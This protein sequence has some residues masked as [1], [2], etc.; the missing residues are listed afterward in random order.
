MVDPA[1]QDV[2]QAWDAVD[3][4]ADAAAGKARGVFGRAM[5]WLGTW[6]AKPPR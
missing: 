4:R 5:A 6:R 3:A 1:L 2:E